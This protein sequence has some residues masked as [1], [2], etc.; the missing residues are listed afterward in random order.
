MSNY[1]AKSKHFF[2]HADLDAFFASVEQLDHPEYRGKPV[3]VGGLPQDKRSVVSTASYEAR[4]FGVH[5][6]MP[7]AKAYQLCPQGIFVHGR[8]KRYSELSYQI[9]QIFADFSPDVQ[10]MSID[11]AFIDLTGTE[12][13]FGS[14]VD[15]ARKIKERVKA[16][17]GL[18]LSIG[19]APTKYL[20]KLASD[21]KKPDGLYVIE[22]GSEETFMLNLPL[23]KVWGIG[24]KTYQ[25]LKA[26]G[27]RTTRDI[28]EKS[29]EALT[30]MYGQ[31]TG[32]FL[33]NVV[34]GIETVS[35]DRK[36]KSHSI[37]NETTFPFDVSDIYTAETSI[38]ELCHSVIFRL[39]KENGFS[40]TVQVKIRYEDFSTVSIQQTYPQSILTLD[41]L[42]SAAKELFEKKY[43]RG[44]GIRLLGIALENIENKEETYQQGLFDDNNEKKQKVEKA[45]LNLEKKHPEIKIHKARMLQNINK[46][47]KLIVL[48]F[49]I[50]ASNLIKVGPLFAQEESNYEI[51][52]SWS[53]N[54]KGSVDSTFGLGNPFGLSAQPPVFDQT[55]DLSALIHITPKFYFEMEFLDKFTDNTYTLGYKGDSYL[56][57]FKLS[58]R[59]ISFPK[60]Y[61]SVINGYDIQ[62]GKNEAPGLML[63]FEDFD[64]KKWKGDFL[65]RYDMTQTKEA[66]FYGMNCLTDSSSE[67]YTYV[68]SNTFVIPSQ[69][70]F[71]IRNIYL[72]SQGGSYKD[73]RGLLYHKLSP[74]D[75]VIDEKKGLLILSTAV[76]SLINSKSRPYIIITFDDEVYCQ[77]LLDDTG[78]YSDSSTFAG[79]IQEFFNSK[80]PSDPSLDLND[81]FS[82]SPG[83]LFTNINGSKG[84]IIQSPDFFSP[85]LCANIYKVTD[86][87]SSE[88]FIAERISKSKDLN[89][90][91]SLQKDFYYSA[92]DFFD[93]KQSYAQAFNIEYKD[94]S[95]NPL[96]PAWR[97]PFAD[98]YPQLY[99]SEKFEAPLLF[100]QRIISPV[101]QFDIG[102]KASAGSIRVYKNGQLL[103]G[104]LYDPNTGFITMPE[105][106]GELDTI[107]ITYEEEAGNQENGF[108]T[109]AS[110][111]AYNILPSLVFDISFTGKYQ[112]DEK[113]KDEEKISFSALTSGL[114]YNG[115]NFTAYDAITTALETSPEANPHFVT[116][117]QAGLKLQNES[118]FIQ[119]ISSQGIALDTSKGKKSSDYIISSLKGDYEIFNLGLGADLAL[120]YTSLQNAGHFIKT[121]KALFDFLSFEEIYRY[122]LNELE[123]K[124]SLSLNF[125]KNKYFAFSLE[126][127]TSAKKNASLQKQAY[128]AQSTSTIKIKNSS[129]TALFK[130]TAFGQKEDLSASF[131]QLVFPN[132]FLSWYEI[133]K[134]E[135]SIG[136][137]EAA[138]QTNFLVHYKGNFLPLTL[139]PE[140]SLEVSGKNENTLLKD[141]T[142][143]N[144]LKFALPFSTDNNSF[145]FNFT[146][147][148][149]I[150]SIW[151]SNN[152]GQDINFIFGRQKDFSFFYKTI[153]IYSLFDKKAGDNLMQLQKPGTW[154][155]EYD[156][157]W[158]RKLFNSIKDLYIPSSASAA[159][160]RDILN[161]GSTV[162]DTY[163]IKARLASNF[164]N[165]FGANSQLQTFNWYRQEE[166]TGF[167]SAVIKYLPAAA[168]SPAFQINSGSLLT[169]Y[170]DQQNALNVNADFA[171]DNYL[172]WTFKNSASW[173][174][175]SQKSLLLELTKLCWK[176][177]VNHTLDC[178]VTDS[179]SLSLS[180]Q[181]KKHKEIYSYSRASEISFLQNFN[182]SS[183]AG[184]SFAYEEGKTLK[185]GLNYELGLKI[186]F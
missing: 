65:L 118:G 88:F 24:D 17:T 168:S 184:I 33:Y 129:H 134:Q 170:I 103:S 141:F 109:T 72:Q 1:D 2:L 130:F 92:P 76:E 144:E 50:L 59:M 133:S 122:S 138:R 25:A 12:R 21:M 95:L 93:N 136:Q 16:E 46:G 15:T 18:T 151:E 9:M 74:Q 140:I 174:R 36:T 116:K 146:H 67:L 100:T 152:Y 3:I 131:T 113:K 37:S 96:S 110:G 102:K 117:N 153:P 70:V 30:F 7:T 14:P 40:R 41:S 106:V 49:L 112:T 11:E 157:N 163:Q 143:K 97:Y 60:Y 85:Y 86:S 127:E 77:S 119:A 114:S 180:T 62:G 158:K 81:F 185:L 89:Y 58:N 125:D 84:Y 39:L 35:F 150:N 80:N 139:S 54:L 47:L 137:K 156:I 181:N 121:N 120:S 132:Y 165:L 126:G 48:T 23:K 8:M 147:S 32:T 42:Y 107:Y 69:A 79:Q 183:A 91:A 186:S 105:E 128:L 145:S 142:Q 75:F 159:F 166:Y 154:S 94:Q 68:A 182:L 10:Q 178:K 169:F 164:I 171:I 160:A 162:K 135:F 57:E 123:K 31:N 101:K 53:G 155:V 98:R 13:L 149:L 51:S 124:D 87:S 45:I 28:H 175:P 34:R 19:L 5:S 26:A 27:L 83:Q 66:L 43:E 99:L 55:V 173:S 177:W 63:H 38:L 148:G 22:E 44:R 172:N 6:A 108:V 29:L 52:G 56:N 179:L 161:T 90:S 71:H 167:L 104:A 78:S 4:V 82:L 64:T 61:S 73:S 176:G 115:K 111:F 20:A